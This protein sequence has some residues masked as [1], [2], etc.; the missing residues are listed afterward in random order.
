MIHY[1]LH[2]ANG[3]EFDG[4]FRDSAAF[5]DQARLGLLECPAC[6]E[7]RVSRALMAPAVMKPRAARE[8]VPAPQ[9]SP[10]PVPARQPSPPGMATAQVPAQV[11]ATLQRLRADVEKNCDYVGPAFPEVALGIH[12]GEIEPRGIY[13][14]ASPDQAEMLAD[15][16]V[17]VARIPW[18]PRA[19]G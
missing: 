14:E 1:T 12:R 4:W 7:G 17:K 9:P 16:G 11:L 15:E 8:P 2:C 19:D 10:A 6:G 3:H 5:D 18:V 13:G